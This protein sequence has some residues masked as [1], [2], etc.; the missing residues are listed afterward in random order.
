MVLNEWDTLLA[1]GLHQP[2]FNFFVFGVAEETVDVEEH[3]AHLHP[4]EIALISFPLGGFFCEVE[5][6]VFLS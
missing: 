1:S 5:Q 2:G 6:V 3:A 4:F